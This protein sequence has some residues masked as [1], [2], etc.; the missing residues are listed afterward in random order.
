MNWIPLNNKT[1]FSLQRGYSKPEQL[2]A[3]CKEFGYDTCAIT[4]INT[5]SGAVAFYKTCKANDVKPIIGCTFE[6]ESNRPVTLLAKNKEGWFDL[7]DLVSKKNSYSDDV[8]HKVVKSHSDNLICIDE[9]QQKP[10]YYAKK[11]DAELHRIL[12][13]SGMKTN[14]TKAKEKVKQDEFKKFRGFFNSDAYSLMS[15]DEVKSAYSQDII[16]KIDSISQQCEEYD[17]LGKPMLPEFDCP[18]G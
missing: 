12:L 4:D 17:I 18:E 8:V 7:I 10:S 13:C 3:K 11:E 2:V 9:L 5:I 1:H 15:P 6:F 14:M 16:A